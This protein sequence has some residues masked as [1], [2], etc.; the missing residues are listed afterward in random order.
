MKSHWTL[1][2]L[3]SSALVV[4]CGGSGTDNS[5]DIEE[6]SVTPG[7]PGVAQE[8]SAAEPAPAARGDTSAVT[9]RS[10]T[11]APADVDR[12]NDLQTRPSTSSTS[13]SRLPEFREVT[14]PAGTALPLE[15]LTALSS[16]TARVETPVR[17]RLSQAL[18]VD[19]YTVMPAGAVLTGTVTDV[20]RAGRVQGRSRL[21][22][23]FN[24]A[25]VN[26]GREDLRTNPLAFE[27]GSD[28][29]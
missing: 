6:N 2:V 22:F 16:E 19:G 7:A 5:Q 12:V 10:A 17:A 23:V 25:E 26:G 13:R 21:A 28:Q 9:R 15:L 24:E 27:G 29:G 11:L 14:V 3:L 8:R 18:V 4:G 20:D 1:S